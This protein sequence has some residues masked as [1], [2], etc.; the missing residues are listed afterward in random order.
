MAAWYKNNEYD[1]K[2][3]ILTPTMIQKTASSPPKLR[4]KATEIRSLVLFVQKT[5]EILLSDNS[6]VKQTAKDMGLRLPI[7][8]QTPP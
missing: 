6:S 8:I 2:F 3:D 5:C 1:A 4:G 7:V